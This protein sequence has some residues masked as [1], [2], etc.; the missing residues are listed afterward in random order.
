MNQELIDTYLLVLLTVDQICGKHVIL[1]K[2]HI[3]RELQTICTQGDSVATAIAR[4]VELGL[5][6]VNAYL[7]HKGT[8]SEFIKSH[9]TSKDK[10]SETLR[11]LSEGKT[12]DEVKAMSE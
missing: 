6:E 12:F 1:K 5:V 11:Q 7:S 9:M 8:Y 10:I 3:Q 4:F 2:K